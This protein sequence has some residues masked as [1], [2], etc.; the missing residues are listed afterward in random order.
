MVVLAHAIQLKRWSGGL[1]VVLEK[2][3]GVTLVTKLRAILL[4]EPDF[5]ASN[6]KI[7]CGVRMMGQAR[8]H[9]LMSDEIYSEK[10]WMADNGTLTKTLFFNIARQARTP[11]S[12][13]SVDASICYDRIA[14]AIALLVFQELGIP[15]SAIES[16]LGAVEN[17]KFFLHTGFGDSKRFAS[18]GVS[19]KVQGLTQ[20]YR[21]SPSGWAVIS[22]VI[23]RA[24][25]KKGHGAKFRCPITNL[26]AHILAIF[27]INDTD[28]LHINFD[29]DKS[30][31]DAHATIHNSVN[32]WVTF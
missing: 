21:A 13:A 4:M 2:T 30:V 12:I 31:D 6:N 26:S 23:L 8:D 18:N 1:S 28:L 29:H 20:G 16:M 10:N 25:G 5:N 22:I 15:K 27:Y 14:H 3:L 9:N 11:A 19:V 24:H 7:I 17:M 32:S